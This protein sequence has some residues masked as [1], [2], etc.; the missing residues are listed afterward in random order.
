M[1]FVGS[2]I[3]AVPGAQGLNRFVNDEPRGAQIE[4]IR[5]ANLLRKRAHG[6]RRRVRP[7]AR[8]EPFDQFGESW[9]R[10]SLARS[11]V[12]VQDANDYLP[13]TSWRRK[14]K[15]HANF[16]GEFTSGRFKRVS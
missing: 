9:G 14:Y 1:S 15:L 5:V 6:R 4:I 8:I 12:L 11:C 10:H 2:P 16:W 7:V 13:L 3:T